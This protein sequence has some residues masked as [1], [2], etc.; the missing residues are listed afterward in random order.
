MSN[1]AKAP[2][3]SHH[4]FKDEEVTI[5]VGEEELYEDSG[6]KSHVEGQHDHNSGHHDHSKCGGHGHSHGGGHG[7]KH[8]KGNKWYLSHGIEIKSFVTGLVFI[9]WFSVF[10]VRFFFA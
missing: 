9:A 2:Q 6:S 5:E 7:H 4:S 1:S 10:F 3:D 8:G